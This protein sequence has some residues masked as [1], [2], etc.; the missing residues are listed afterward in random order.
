MPRL[1]R[2][3]FSAVLPAILLAALMRPAPLHAQP[4][5]A[6]TPGARAFVAC[7]SDAQ[8]V[9]RRLVERFL[10]ADCEACWQQLPPYRAGEAPAPADAVIDWVL[11]GRQGDEAPL[12]AV[13]LRDALWRLQARGIDAPSGAAPAAQV[14]LPPQRRLLDP[15]RLRVAHGSAVLGHVGVSIEMTPARGGPWTVWLVL[16]EQVPAGTEGTPVAREVVRGSLRLDWTAR[17][18]PGQAATPVPWRERRVMQLPDGTQADRLRL[19]A[20]AE[21]T[22]GRIATMARSACPPAR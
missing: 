22:Q 2:A 16:T 10:S 4:A 21:D 18:V 19:T 3:P 11:P 5:A 7:S 12:S 1:F 17:A 20:W 6:K 9:P 13:A 8:A 15:P 14:L